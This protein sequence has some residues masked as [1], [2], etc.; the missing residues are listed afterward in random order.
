MS[1]NVF[2]LISSYTNYQAIAK[3]NAMTPALRLVSEEHDKNTGDIL[4]KI[5]IS[6]KNI[7]P[8]L[9]LEDCSNPAILSNFSKHD[10]EIIQ[11][12]LANK[13]RH[14][15]CSIIARTYNKKNKQF[16]YTIEYFDSASKIKRYRI[17]D[18]QTLLLKEI[19][20]FDVND[21]LIIKSQ[22]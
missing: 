12:Y 17:F 22:F 15:S 3:V 20:K 2:K 11:N 16:Y 5:Q 18:D 9:P 14:I 6:G 7:F 1:N 21:K 19:E 13:Q 8:V 4:F 10:Q